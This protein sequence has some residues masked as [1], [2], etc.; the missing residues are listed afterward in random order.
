MLICRPLAGTTFRCFSSSKYLFT[1]IV[2]RHRLRWRTDNTKKISVKC[3][4][5][6]LGS[7]TCEATPPKNNP[8]RAVGLVCVGV[9]RRGGHARAERR[10]DRGLR[11]SNSNL[12]DGRDF[13]RQRHRRRRHFESCAGQSG[14]QQDPCHHASRNSTNRGRGGLWQGA[15]DYAHGL[16]RLL[17]NS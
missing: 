3:R 1:I 13:R 11:G 6:V 10:L 8:P 7:V 4:A 2:V 5:A 15:N 17:G 14:Y 12:R 16:S 9:F